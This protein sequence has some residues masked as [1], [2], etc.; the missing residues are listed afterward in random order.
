[1]TVEFPLIV[2]PEI[3]VE[4]EWLSIRED[5]RMTHD[6][7]IE[8]GRREEGAF[9]DPSKCTM[10]INNRDGLY[11]PTNPDSPL[12]G[13]IGRN[14]PFRLAIFAG[15][16]YARLPDDQESVATTPDSPQISVTGDIDIRMDFALRS[17]SGG[18][19]G[20][21]DFGDL[22]EKGEIGDNSFQ[23]RQHPNRIDFSWSEDGASV[24]QNTVSSP[25]LPSV[26]GRRIR[27][28][29]TLLTDDLT[30]NHVV[31][32]YTGETINGP[33]TQLGDPEVRAGVTQ[34]HDSA[35]ALEL[36]IT[37]SINNEFMEAYGLQIHDGIDGPTV[38]QADFTALEIG[39]ISFTDDAGVPWTLT[40]E[41]E[42]T[43]RQERF[44][45]EISEWPQ[46]WD[47]SGNDHWV[48]ITASGS[49]RRIRQSS[50]VLPSALQT[51]T[52]QFASRARS[53]WPL[54]EQAGSGDV[55]APSIGDFFVRSRMTDNDG[56]RYRMGWGQGVLG[57]HMENVLNCP[58]DLLT[59]VFGNL[60]SQV[61]DR[62]DMDYVRRGAGGDVTFS[63][64]DVGAGTDDDNR[65]IWHLI[66]EA[67]TRNVILR[68]EHIG[69]T[70]SSISLLSSQ[71]VPTLFNNE[72]HT[73][74]LR[75]STTSWTIFI[76]GSEIDSD[77]HAF[78][79]QPAFRFVLENDAR[80][81]LDE[82]TPIAVGHVTGYFVFDSHPTAETIFNA[83][84]GLE[85]APAG[86]NFHRLGDD[87]NTDLVVSG[88]FEDT[89]LAGPQ[90]LDSFLS[91]LRH[92]EQLDGGLI[93]DSRD[94]P[95]LVY[96]TNRS[97]YLQDVMLTLNWSEG[98]LGSAPA[99]TQDDQKLINAVIATRFDGGRS[100]FSLDE[101]P[102]SINNPP[103]GVGRYDT[104]VSLNAFRDEDLPSQAGWRVHLGTIDEQRWPSVHI[105]MANERVRYLADDV[106]ALD[107]QDRMH[108]VNPPEGYPPDDIDLII[109]GYTERINAFRWDFLLNCSPAS[110][111]N[112][113]VIEPTETVTDHFEE[114]ERKFE[115][116][117]GGDAA[118]FRTTDE[119]FSGSWSFRSGVITH[120]E[121]SDAVIIVPDRAIKMTLMYLVSSEED[122]D[123]F[124]VHLDEE[125]ALEASGEVDW[126]RAVFDV[127]GVTTATLRYFK[128]S[129]VSDGSDAAFVDDLS[130]ELLDVP[131]DK[132]SRLD[133]AGSEL[134]DSVGAG[135]DQ[136][137]VETIQPE[138]RSSPLWI[139]SDGIDPVNPADFPFDVRTGGET[140]RVEAIEPTEWDNFRRTETDT[141]GV[142][143]SGTAWLEVGGDPTD[144]SV[145]S[146]RGIVT[147]QASSSSVR[148]QTLTE[149]F[150]T[151]CEILVKISVDQTATG[152][153]M[154]PSV[155]LRRTGVGAEYYRARLHFGVGGQLFMSVTSG[156][157]AIGSSPSVPLTYDPGDEFHFR[158]RLTGNHVL[159]RA[160]QTGRP[161]FDGDQLMTE[162]H[163]W[164]ID[165]T[166]NVDTVAAGA[167][168]ISASTFGGNTNVNPQLRFSDFQV[169]NPQ[170]FGVER[171]INGVVKD[172][173]QGSSIS[174]N[175]PG[176]I[177]L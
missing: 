156:T 152:A 19:G 149:E 90:Q 56:V 157:T 11:T 114:E 66:T 154:L 5:L 73:I 155:L 135:D 173:D 33:W 113:V 109:E 54:T 166:V 172:H 51:L 60:D 43:D 36:G 95:G 134:Y 30:G 104:S 162:P 131:P 89:Q 28:R 87:N 117:D 171:G 16:P 4:E 38:V 39:T 37:Q 83:A 47:L 26:S 81:G 146:N 141:W 123:F 75:V 82:H 163:I 3:L 76:D 22:L 59:Y 27:F 88:P 133:T 119:A 68:V 18:L 110:P 170:R 63:I 92:Q 53:Y 58:T 35:A 50:A 32:F 118:W 44:A 12:F 72:L 17:W 105:N 80:D 167:V 7:Q 125:L 153:S 140:M 86:D 103:D 130:F 122:F 132:P 115:I 127:S 143:S 168:G 8:Y 42:I 24:F 57:A 78:T 151:D 71:N 84:N 106:L 2:E 98:E 1:M 144:R 34:I 116:Q 112:V 124:Q 94:G 13:K 97:R 85:G 160:W 100:E 129:S 101:G 45:G 111:W 77:S 21:Q 91:L 145:S 164:H 177:A 31:T 159:A 49:T 48:P 46:R 121:Q 169:I 61:S 15:S 6:V 126:T 79:L 147:L 41:A 29:V 55:A 108:I 142:A 158:V 107:T 139:V 25:V 52:E 128:D 14:T 67:D 62:W 69:E 23:L 161:G 74:R 174:L 70:T 137:L 136:F 65:R 40:G 148:F 175:R 138:T 20:F 102:L 9:A 99:P 10:V 176:V 96:R 120:D 64:M 150:L 165:R 93:Y